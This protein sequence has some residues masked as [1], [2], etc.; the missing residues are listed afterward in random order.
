MRNGLE[1]R[2]ETYSMTDVT[3]LIIILAVAAATLLLASAVRTLAP[4]RRMRSAHGIEPPFNLRS[5]RNLIS[6][7]EDAF[8][9]ARLSRR[10]Y[11]RLQRQKYR[12]ASAYVSEL[13][14]YASGMARLGQ[15]SRRSSDPQVAAAA[16]AL[17]SAAFRLRFTAA[18]VR[19]NLGLWV[20]FPS[21]RHSL[22]HLIHQYERIQAASAQLGLARYRFANTPAGR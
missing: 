2:Q 1:L 19:L 17:V 15:P 3:T 21:S 6:A 7:D 14:R 4:S 20:L 10:D 16:E 11:N 22:P 5:F 13:S 8:V 18:I 12:I 9:R